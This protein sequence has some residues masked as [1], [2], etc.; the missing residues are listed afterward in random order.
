ML[1]CGLVQ[2][3]SSGPR[4][5]GTFRDERVWSSREGWLADL[6][7]ALAAATHLVKVRSLFLTAVLAAYAKVLAALV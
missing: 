5:A 1:I 4:V 6:C 7:Q 2:S 3:A